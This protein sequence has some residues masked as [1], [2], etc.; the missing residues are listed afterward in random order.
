MV[1]DA[2]LGGSVIV[3][4]PSPPSAASDL[5]SKRIYRAESSGTFQFVADVPLADGT[6]TDNVMSES[7]GVSIPS[8]EWDMP[9]DRLT[10][11]TAMPGGFLAGFLA[12]RFALA[13]HSIR[14][15]GQSRISLPLVKTLWASLL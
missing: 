1:E 13:R 10:G 12:I 14:T 8:I 5:V 6:F 7:L 11:L 9:D 15:P 3:S 4:L 2:P